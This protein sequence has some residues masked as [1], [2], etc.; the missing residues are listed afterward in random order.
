MVRD[1]RRAATLDRVGVAKTAREIA[2]WDRNCDPSWAASVQKEHF[3]DESPIVSSQVLEGAIFPS[4]MSPDD[5]AAYLAYLKQ[6]A[7]HRQNPNAWIVSQV[8]AEGGQSAIDMLNIAYA[9]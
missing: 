9:A 8:R 2:F 4:G 7:E 3:P 1:D 5:L 6:Y